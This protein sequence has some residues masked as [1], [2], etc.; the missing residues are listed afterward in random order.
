MALG[1]LAGVTLGF[2][3]LTKLSA[4]AVVP[5]LAVCVIWVGAR[6]WQ[7]QSGSWGDRIRR[8]AHSRLTGVLGAC[9]GAGII[10]VAVAW[11]ALVVD[12]ARQI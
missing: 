2:A 11:P 12:P 9:L 4:A 10:T 6:T 5:A 3:G 7:R 8:L 1:A